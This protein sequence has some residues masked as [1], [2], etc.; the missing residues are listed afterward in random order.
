M[1]K[2]T[3]TLEVL[4]D[5]ECDEA[6]LEHV[7]LSIVDAANDYKASHGLSPDDADSSVDMVVLESFSVNG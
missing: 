4:V 2:A 7:A 5:G 1:K 3:I 6:F